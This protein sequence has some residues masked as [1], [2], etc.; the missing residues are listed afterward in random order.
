MSSSSSPLLLP[1]LFPALASAISRLRMRKLRRR[2]N[3]NGP[4][5]RDELNLMSVGEASRCCDGVGQCSAGPL[6]LK[7][8]S[9]TP[10]TF[11]SN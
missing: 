8:G 5:R 1:V 10:R 9:A 4:E 11:C 7:E 3:P 6:G 2:W